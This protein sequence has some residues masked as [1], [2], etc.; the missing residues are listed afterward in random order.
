MK[1]SK[2]IAE[3]VTKEM[4]K[5]IPYNINLMDERGMIIGSGDKQRIGSLHK[6]AS[7]VIEQ[8]SNNE[9][10]TEG[11]GMRPGV[12]EPIIINGEIIGVIGI[13]GHPDEVRP[14]SKL[15]GATAKLLIE[16]ESINKKAQNDRIKRETFYHELS[17]RKASY[18]DEFLQQG[19]M[20]GIDLTRKCQAI[21]IKGNLHSKGMM[22]FFDGFRHFLTIDNSKRVLFIT[23]TNSF[24]EAVTHL[25]VSKE[26]EKVAI[27]ESEEFAASSL[28]QAAN[29]FS[30]GV[31]I[32]PSEKVYYYNHLKLFIHL[33]LDNR[34][35]HPSILSAL[36][37]SGIHQELFH[38]LQVYMEE[39]GDS[40][41]T[42]NKLKIHRNTLNYRLEKIKNLTGKNP[43]VILELFEL[44]C[45]IIW[46]K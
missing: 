4:M 42:A 40:N 12:N 43:K 33:A 25:L 38:T 28:E 21:L 20:Y 7:K 30:V 11:D 19:K 32:R 37:S 6:G 34:D 23:E 2:P 10:Y 14:F 31:K 9:I 45:S 5:I 27:G 29:A 13:T 44:I 36:E 15:V 3:K 17:Y 46:S 26:I 22:E 8:K 24:K 1:L 16:Q 41:N 35:Y 18:D 39:N